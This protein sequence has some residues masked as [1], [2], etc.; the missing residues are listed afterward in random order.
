SVAIF[1]AASGAA[2]SATMTIGRR[3]PMAAISSASACRRSSRRATIASSWPLRAKTRASSMPMPADAPVIKVT[4][5]RGDL[6]FL[7]L[8]PFSRG[9]LSRFRRDLL[10]AALGRL[11]APGPDHDDLNDDQRDH[12]P[13]HAGQAVINDQVA[14]DE[15]RH[16]GG[17]AAER[18]AD[19]V[20]T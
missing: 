1:F 9:D 19:A 3:G 7:S 13:N 20:G 2:R 14:D 15:G 12:Q 11:D 8:P 5:P 10:E 4:R 18:V 16:H 6:A 17:T